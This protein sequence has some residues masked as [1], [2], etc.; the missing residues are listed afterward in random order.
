MTPSAEAVERSAREL[1]QLL[2]RSPESWRQFEGLLLRFQERLAALAPAA[3]AQRGEVDST[4]TLRAIAER[5][6]LHIRQ[7]ISGDHYALGLV[8]ARDHVLNA[9]EHAALRSVAPAADAQHGNG[10]DVERV[11][12]AIYEACSGPWEFA[13]GAGKDAARHEAR[14]ALAALRHDST[15]DRAKGEANWI[16]KFTDELT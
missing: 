11:A 9:L 2:G 4:M 3:D 10:D 13:S 15:A 7:K 16:D 1:C 5:L 8:E 12:R 14:A 6:V